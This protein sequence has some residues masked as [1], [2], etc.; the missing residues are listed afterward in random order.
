MKATTNFDDTSRK[1]QYTV[2]QK[3]ANPVP[4]GLTGF[5]ITTIL[6]NIHNAGT[7][8]WAV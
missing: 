5:G 4:L 1:E 7:T 6:L 2:T 3:L 8:L